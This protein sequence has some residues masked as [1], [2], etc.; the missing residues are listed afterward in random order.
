MHSLSG[1]STGHAYQHTDASTDVLC[2]SLF[3][4]ATLCWQLQIRNSSLISYR[5]GEI[6]I[7]LWTLSES[8][9]YSGFRQ[10]RFCI[11][12]LRVKHSL[13]VS[14]FWSSSGT[15]YW[16]LAPTL[17]LIYYGVLRCCL[18]TLHTPFFLNSKYEIT[19]YEAIRLLRIF[20]L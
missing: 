9:K 20:S 15:V 7:P 16:L 8:L 5:E 17:H 4:I 3:T 10:H 19:L 18:M 14:S 11:V 2:H 13:H 6:S 12:M 1:F